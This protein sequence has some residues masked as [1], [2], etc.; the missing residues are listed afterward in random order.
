MIN[1]VFVLGRTGSGKSTTVRMLTEELQQ[2]GW[3]VESF[4]DYPFLREMFLVD[5]GKRF[6]P[7]EH[8]GFEVLDPWVYEEA[9]RRLKQ[10]IQH[11]QPPS[12]KTLITIEFTSNNY[13]QA[14]KLFGSEFLQEAH[15]L[16]MLADLATCLSRV[17]QRTIHPEWPDDYYVL[18]T[19]LLQHY[20]CP[21]M[22]PIINNEYATKIPNMGYLDELREY[23]R[24]LIPDLL[25]KI[26][27]A[28]PKRDLSLVG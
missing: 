3:A 24:Q 16:F 22:P 4:N 25:K 6:R 19:V 1:K 13:L 11:F 23:I 7:T 26:E 15:Y 12:P 8:N 17:N 28:S 18:D 9:F 21:Y 27:R 2:L 20:P 14:L 10:K 5:D